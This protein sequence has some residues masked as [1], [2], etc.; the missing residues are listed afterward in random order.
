MSVVDKVRTLLKIRQKRERPPSGI[1]PTIG[2]KI[3][4][5]S[6]RMTVEAGMTD[7]LW[8][9]L[10]QAG[11]REVTFRPDRRRYRDVPHSRVAELYKAPPGQWRTMLMAALKE[12]AERPQ[13]R[14]G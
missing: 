3:V 10:L 9:F 2:A 4:M 5:G 8:H 14:A 13:V 7:E 6:V 12:A 11:F 1:R